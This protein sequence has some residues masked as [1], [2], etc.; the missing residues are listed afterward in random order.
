VPEHIIYPIEGLPRHVDYAK[1]VGEQTVQLRVGEGYEGG[2]N[3]DDN[4]ESIL[5]REDAARLDSELYGGNNKHQSLNVGEIF[6]H[7]DVPL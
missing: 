7:E 3:S 6:S 5:V 2:Y 1:H 4:Q